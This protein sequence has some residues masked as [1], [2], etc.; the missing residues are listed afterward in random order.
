MSDRRIPAAAI[1]AGVAAA[2]GAALVG[3][4]ALRH[5]APVIPGVGNEGEVPPFEFTVGRAT[6]IP[7]SEG[8][9]QR[10][11]SQARAAAETAAGVLS[12]LYVAAFLDPANWR[13][14]R[15]EAAWELFA[16]VAQEAAR[17]DADVLT[18]GP[19]L[20]AGLERIEPARGRLSA[21]VLVDPHGRP[22]AV[23]AIV[24]FTALAEGKD[25][26]VTPL[27][28][29]GQYFL[30]RT[31]GA[32]RILSYDVVREDGARGTATATATPTGSAP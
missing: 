27:V 3:I 16:G 20:G 29:S 24:R 17:R 12:D 15:Y 10:F 28:S 6:A 19:S 30:R 23:V 5:G 18:V 1:A 7:T 21:K 26:A 14:G 2:I 9:R 13:E 31:D 32:W 11:R 4:L 25:G 22:L 8:E